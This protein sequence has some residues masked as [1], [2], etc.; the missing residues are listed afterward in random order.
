MRRRVE[1][2]TGCIGRSR[3]V[4]PAHVRAHRARQP[5]AVVEV[6]VVVPLLPRERPGGVGAPDQRLARAPATHELGG[7][8]LLVE[9]GGR[10]LRLEESCE[11]G[12]VLA[13][14]AEGG[15]A[16]VAAQRL[17]LGHFEG[18]AGELAGVAE[19]ELARRDRGLILGRGRRSWGTGK[20]RLRDVVAVAE[21][22]DVG[23]GLQAGALEGVDD[24]ERVAERR[25]QRRGPR[26]ELFLRRGVERGDE[27]QP[28]GVAEPTHPQLGR[29]RA[30]VAD[31]PSPHGGALDECGLE[32]GKARGGHPQR[33]QAGGRHAQGEA[34]GEAWWRAAWR[35]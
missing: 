17:G 25:P 12:R 32:A 4:R 9:A 26:V 28:V 3:W 13:Q 2:P 16:P 1:S 29:A 35:R 27:V 5:V 23:A 30:D 20:D 15:E 19:E 8:Q 34:R 24:V 18:D 21:V 7:Q 10:G 22:D 6:A 14:Y 33:R 31:A 11:P